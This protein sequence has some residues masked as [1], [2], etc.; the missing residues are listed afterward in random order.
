MLKDEIY[1][2]IR[3]DWQLRTAIAD[4]LGVSEGTIYTYAKRKSQRLEHYLAIKQLLLHTKKTDREVFKT[5][6]L[7]S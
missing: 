5:S 7:C 3:N 6:T 4:M 1:H 2:L